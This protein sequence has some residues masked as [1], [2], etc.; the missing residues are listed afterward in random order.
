M[1]ILALLLKQI[2]RFP[3][4]VSPDGRELLQSSWRSLAVAWRTTSSSNKDE[5]IL[6][7]SQHNTQMRF[8]RASLPWFSGKC[9]LVTEF[10]LHATVIALGGHHKGVIETHPG[11]FA[12]MSCLVR[13]L[14]VS[15]YS[16]SSLYIHFNLC[17]AAAKERIFFLA[18]K[19]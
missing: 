1:Y 13:D 4:A 16:L 7:S 3:P 14:H 10:C 8:S 15:L 2:Q 6:L 11:L 9:L 18:S 5:E 17:E 12:S 19:I